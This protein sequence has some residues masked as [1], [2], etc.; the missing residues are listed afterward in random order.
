MKE[1]IETNT[2]IRSIS[3]LRFFFDN[4]LLATGTGV[5]W[6]Y[7]ARLFLLTN[8]H[9][10]TGRHQVTRKPLSGHGGI[11][12]KLEFTYWEREGD[13]D[14]M[15][16]RTKGKGSL[17]PLYSN[18]DPPRPNWGEHFYW[19][20]FLDVVCL[21]VT[22]L[23]NNPLFESIP[24]NEIDDPPSRLYSG[25]PAIIQGYHL[26]LQSP[27]SLIPTLSVGKIISNPEEDPYNHPLIFVDCSTGK[28]MS[29]SLA[30][31]KTDNNLGGFLGIYSGRIKLE[32]KEVGVVWKRSKIEELV[33]RPIQGTLPDDIQLIM[34]NTKAAMEADGIDVT[35]LDVFDYY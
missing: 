13:K 33:K 17:Y 25:Q 26:G 11:P 10:V 14:S 15:P 3:Y 19:R 29:G 7:E 16:F 30:L 23:L 34:N 20:F 9:N 4:T 12:N 5:F 18:D 28:G 27:K 2:W 35:K 31:V 32:N 6:K 8:W 24:A 21:D 1:K 22:S